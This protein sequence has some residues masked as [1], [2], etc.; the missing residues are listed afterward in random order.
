MSSVS[1]F[2][3]IDSPHSSSE[4]STVI[5]FVPIRPSLVV[6]DDFSR[7]QDMEP[8]IHALAITS[9]SPS[10][11]FL[12]QDAEFFIEDDMAIFCVSDVIWLN[13][14]RLVNLALCSIRLKIQNCLFK[15]HRFFLDRESSIFPKGTGSKAQPIELPGVTR[16]EFKSLLNFFYNG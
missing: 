5:Q 15:V 16:L 4:C 2:E 3:V 1:S 14:A 9:R 11:V 13:C 7:V 6:E 8:V 10:P 12:D